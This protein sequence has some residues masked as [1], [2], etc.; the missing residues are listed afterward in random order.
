MGY[1][2]TQLNWEGGEEQEA[3]TP[4]VIQALPGTRKNHTGIKDGN[5]KVSYKASLKLRHTHMS[6]YRPGLSCLQKSQSPFRS[7]AQMRAVFF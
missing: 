4:K 3:D 5:Q 2:F 7:L 1:K 6:H